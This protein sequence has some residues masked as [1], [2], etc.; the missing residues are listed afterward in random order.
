MNTLS[1]VSKKSS[2][3]HY[4]LYDSRQ[5]WWLGE[6]EYGRRYKESQRQSRSK[7]KLSY[8]PSQDGWF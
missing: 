8:F 2:A 5:I 4:R 6:A 7:T 3:V 1:S